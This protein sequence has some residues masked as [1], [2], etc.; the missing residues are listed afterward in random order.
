VFVWGVRNPWR[1]SFDRLTGDLWLADV[2][3]DQLEEI[4]VLY[5]S[6][7]GGRGANLGWSLVEGSAAFNASSPPA[8]DYVAPIYE[9]GPESGCSIT[10]GYV[11]RGQAIPELFGSYIFG[12][13]CSGLMWGLASS[14]EQG[15][16]DSFELGVDAGTE[17]LASFGEGPDG[18][19]YVLSFDNTVY[20]LSRA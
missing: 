15:L 11:Y 17:G 8:E 1:I 7:G 20:R 16:L 18:E 5:A 9:Y 4:D 19:L 14:Q 12:D 10:G 6:D 3:E 2:G 13:F